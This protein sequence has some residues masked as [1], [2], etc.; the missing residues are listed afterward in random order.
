MQRMHLIKKQNRNL[1]DFQ[2][3]MNLDLMMICSK[4]LGSVYYK[5]LLECQAFN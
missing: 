3:K 4:G 1:D 5:H 2:R